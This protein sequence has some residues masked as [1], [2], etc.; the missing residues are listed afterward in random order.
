MISSFKDWQ[1]PKLSPTSSFNLI[2]AVSFGLFI[3]ASLID[4]FPYGGLNVHPSLLPRYR[5]A[6]PIQRTLLNH[7]KET[8]VTI[9]TLDKERF[10]H[11][12]I[13]MQS[14]PPI[15]IP[16]K[17]SYRTLH[18]NLAVWGAD[19]LVE[20]LRQRLFVPPIS[21]IKNSYQ[22][23]VARKVTSEDS[24]ISWQDWSADEMKLRAEML[25]S[26]WTELGAELDEPSTPRKRTILTEIDVLNWDP[27]LDIGVGCFRYVKQPEEMM[28]LRCKYGW[29]RVGAVKV[30][31]K[32]EIEGGMWI[33]SLQK[34]GVGRK[35]W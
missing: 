30:E 27:E 1:L 3:P 7:D 4:K 6:A 8:G 28:V 5:G 23:S 18:D 10:D 15:S 9:Q 32:K 26:V 19:M 16:P 29:V 20:T 21:D 24:H 33:R 25:G 22:A 13:L 11:G 35:F 17:T 2:I 12:K 31:G 34:R 14:S